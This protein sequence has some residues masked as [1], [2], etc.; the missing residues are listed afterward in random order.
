MGGPSGPCLAVGAAGVE[1][2]RGLSS[3]ASWGRASE[4]ASA[5]GVPGSS[6][7]RAPGLL[8]TLTCPFVVPVSSA[9]PCLGPAGLGAPGPAHLCVSR[10]WRGCVIDLPRTR[11]SPR[12]RGHC[13]P[14]GPP[15]TGVSSAGLSGRPLCFPG[16]AHRSVTQPG[17][18]PP[19]S[20]FTKRFLWRGRAVC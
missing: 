20:R 6:F 2:R 1:S 10:V 11:P 13:V 7:L 4:G 8:V 3:L 16:R 17:R 19:L 18:G 14:L 5:V 15:R 12:T 9:P